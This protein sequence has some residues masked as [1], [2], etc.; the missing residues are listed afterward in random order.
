MENKL[1]NYEVR[2]YSWL[3]P[4][5]QKWRFC[6]QCGL[7]SEFPLIESRLIEMLMEIATDGIDDADFKSIF[8]NYHL[9]AEV[10]L[11]F[12]VDTMCLL[13][14]IENPYEGENNV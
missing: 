9:N 10:L 12:P 14:P 8:D 7:P 11:A 4:E 1:E 2:R 13:T 6:I 5:T 3:E